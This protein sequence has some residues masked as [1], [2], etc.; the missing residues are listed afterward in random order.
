MKEPITAESEKN[1]EELNLLEAQI[2]GVSRSQTA[3]AHPAAELRGIQIN[4]N[5][6]NLD[7]TV[8]GHDITTGTPT[9]KEELDNK[10]KSTQSL[11]KVIEPSAK[12]SE[13]S[14]EKIEPLLDVILRNL[15]PAVKASISRATKKG[16][17]H[18]EMSATDPIKELLMR[19]TGLSPT[20]NE[21]HVLS[22]SA[23]GW[24]DVKKGKTQLLSIDRKKI[25]RNWRFGVMIYTVHDLFVNLKKHEEKEDSFKWFEEASDNERKILVAEAYATIDLIYRLIEKSENNN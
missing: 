6:A 15:S 4:K 16:L 10:L 25:S 5:V 18:F 21:I 14:E 2:K 24:A 11:K 22:Q 3:A 8:K 9:T 17:E 1:L 20:A 19:R 23:Y 13:M 7:D 12:I